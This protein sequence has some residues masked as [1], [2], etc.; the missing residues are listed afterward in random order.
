MHTHTHTESDK[1]THTEADKQTDRHRDRDTET[2][3]DR[4]TEIDMILLFKKR[5]LYYMS[6]KCHDLI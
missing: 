1:H 4:E 2:D 5:T 3:R 6:Y